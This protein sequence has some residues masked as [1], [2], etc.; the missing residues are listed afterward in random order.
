MLVYRNKA[1]Q[2]VIL[3]DATYMPAG[4]HK[5]YRYSTFENIGRT[6]VH[7]AEHKPAYINASYI[8]LKVNDVRVVNPEILVRLEQIDE[9]IKRLRA[10][11]HKILDDEFL[12]FR[13]VTHGDLPQ[14]KIHVYPTA[15]EATNAYNER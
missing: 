7:P 10:E 12:T 8:N 9:Q 6:W 2:T 13:L 5:P 3:K 11:Y 14:A 15:Q 1:K 4:Y